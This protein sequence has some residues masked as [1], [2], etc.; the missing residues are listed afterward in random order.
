MSN[1]TI[2]ST[3]IDFNVNT[4]EHIHLFVFPD[5]YVFASDIKSKGEH[6]NGLRG[7]GGYAVY[8]PN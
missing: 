5:I 1:S 2:N 3:K 4:N 8:I 6:I 7:T